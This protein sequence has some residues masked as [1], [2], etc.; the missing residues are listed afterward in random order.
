MKKIVFI[1]ILALSVLTMSACVNRRNQAPVFEGVNEN[2]TIQLGEAYDPLDGVTAKD[3]EDGDLT[4]DITVSGFLP[5]DVNIGGTLVITLSVTD[6]DG[7]TTT[8]TIN[9]TVE[10]EGEAPVLSGIIAEQTFYIG[11]GTFNPLLGV[12][13]TDA[14]DGN[15]TDVIE[16]IG[17]FLL[18]AT[19]VYTITIRVTNSLNIRTSATITLTVKN[20]EIPTTLTSSP[21][22]ITMWHAMGQANQELMQKYADSFMVIHPN[23]TVNIPAGVGG[24]DVLKSNMINA[25]T[26]GEM[27]NMVQG[28]P[29]HVA[30]YLNGRAVL[31]LNPFI[32]S[33]VWGFPATG[34]GS[35][36][37][38]IESY[39][40]ENTQ[41]DLEGTF[42]SLPFNKSTE[43]MIYNATAWEAATGNTTPPTTWQEI[44]AA[45][46][47]LETYGQDLAEAR[48]RAENPGMAS[49]E[50]NIL[51]QAAKD[52][53]VPAAYS[54]TGN[55]FITF[56]RQWGGQYTG[57]D[58]NT[59]AGQFLWND[60][61]NTT[62]AMQFLY[63]HRDILTL[64]EF[65]NQ[66]FT[67][68][69]FKAQMTFVTISSSAGIR[70]NI[71]P[72]DPSTGEAIFELGV[73]P[74]PYNADRP[75]D[76]QVIQQG[77]NVS[78]MQTGTAQEQLASWLFLKHLINFENTIDWAIN[79]GY[80]PVRESAYNSV[81]YQEFLN[82]PTSNQYNFSLAANAAYLQRN[83][84]FFDPAF[85]GSSRA[86]TQVGLALE[87][88]LL[89][90][91]NIVEALQHAYTEASLGKS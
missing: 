5:E 21:I 83:F 25:I 79:T 24:Y 49:A 71:P 86:R 67:S 11:S 6:S 33:D 54:S 70:H 23:I 8:A 16:V 45:A 22:E 53:I 91:G 82:N 64:P 19:G 57:I 4:S 58:M 48:V 26:A 3:T 35:L 66:T 62:A 77:T 90:D 10:V 75:D 43:V 40:E 34:Q 59:L 2:P 51:I 9:L 36:D 31:S 84:M 38:I 55:A 69:P 74:I 41:Y 1:A 32:N 39:R 52:Q 72:V 56:T 89:G 30:E 7:E 88:I 80:L 61:T 65:W 47:A 20:S 87:R 63:D 27:P 73:A 85:I 46:P 14:V 60:N 81:K 42:Y 68:T 28:Y 37:D 44:I 18:D 12:T 76:R 29:D 13:A 17:T 15:L 78:L 50:L